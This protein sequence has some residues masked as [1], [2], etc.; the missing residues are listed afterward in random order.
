[1]QLDELRLKAR[2]R[3][4]AMVILVGD[5]RAELTSKLASDLVARG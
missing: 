4:A 2:I 3:Q 1:M 5:D